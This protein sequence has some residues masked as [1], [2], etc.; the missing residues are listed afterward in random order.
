MRLSRSIPCA[1]I[2]FSFAAGAAQAAVPL[3]AASNAA[4]FNMTLNLDGEKVALGNQIAAVGHAPPAYNSSTS[5]PSISKTYNSPAGASVSVSG[6]SIISTAKA[7]QPSTTQIVSQGQNAIGSFRAV[8]NT[9]LGAL[10]S[11][12]A[13]NVISRATYTLNRNDTRK[14]VGYADIG[15]VT[16]NAPLLGINNKTFSGSPTVNQVLYQSPDKSVT[17]YLN[18][19]IETMAAGKPTSITVDAIAVEFS[20]AVNQLSIGGDIVVGTAMAK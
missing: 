2:V 6:G 5:L 18:R 13:G 3:L 16:I 1:A 19:Q 12:T 11:I 9:P 7:T 14:A 15:K 8:I 17:V 10:I 4:A 20:K